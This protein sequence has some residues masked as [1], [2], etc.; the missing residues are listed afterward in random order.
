MYTFYFKI[1]ANHLGYSSFYICKLDGSS[2]D[3]TQECLQKTLLL[4]P[5]GDSKYFH[6]NDQGFQGPLNVNLVLPKDLT[7]NHCVLQVYLLG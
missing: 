3:A 5:N 2:A 1:Q 7:C 4:Q 6:P